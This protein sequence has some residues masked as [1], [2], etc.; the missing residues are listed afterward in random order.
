LRDKANPNSR[1]NQRGR[2]VEEVSDIELSDDSSEDE[3]NKNKRSSGYSNM[4][5]NNKS[6]YN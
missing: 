3:R 2:E 5:S 4:G 6:K 1:F